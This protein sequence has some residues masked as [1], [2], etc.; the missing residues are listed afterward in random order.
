MQHHFEGSSKKNQKSFRDFHSI[1][2]C[3]AILLALQKIEKRKTFYDSIRE[4][5]K[6][7]K[8]KLF[9]AIFPAPKGMNMF[10]LLFFVPFLTNEFLHKTHFSRWLGED[11]K[12]I[13]KWITKCTFPCCASEKSDGRISF[14]ELTNSHLRLI[15]S[16]KFM[17]FGGCLLFWFLMST[18]W[19]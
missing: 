2:N 13:Y 8:S 3:C 1:H 14:T 17:M 16:Q 9:A 7:P 11:G 15:K 12:S 5:V 19:L 18:V 6:N 10:F 4:Q